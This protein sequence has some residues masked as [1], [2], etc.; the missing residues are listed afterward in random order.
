MKLNRREFCSVAFAA[1]ALLAQNAPP[2]PMIDR[3]FATVTKL[4]DGVYVTLADPAK[5]PQCLSNGGVIAGRDQVFLI[6]GHFQPAGAALE[7]EAAGMV[8][9]APILAAMNTHYH[10]D[11]TFGNR[12]YA[13]RHIPIMAHER[14][15]GL[16]KERYAALKGVD[17]AP[18][19][20]PLQRKIARAADPEEKKH[21][22]SDL[23]AD[24]WMYMGIDATT[25]AYPTELLA[26][27]HLPKR[28]DLGGISVV[29]ETHPG[30]TPTDLI[31]RIP[32]RDI[33]FTG[34]LLFYREY[35]VAFDAD[36]IAW[37]KVLDGFLSYGR[38]MRFIPGH[39]PVCGI[40]IVRQQI[41][42]MDDLDAHAEKMKRAGV[43]LDE[44]KRRYA[45]PER[46][47]QFEVFSWNWTIGAA[48]ESYYR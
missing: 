47:R 42:L 5:G 32:D 4:A 33:V 16:M 20:A 8:S 15:P 18:L 31:L 29:I 1:P 34:D 17:K 19:L 38:Q 25:I 22:Q 6:E 44:A 27:S 35:P 7:V 9:K 40:E 10:L 3:G 36:M 2:P 37:R 21:L 46:F 12:A 41:D 30:H 26:A 48:I 11:H 45:I 24:Q 23:E 28:I 14:G 43:P 13:D 39:G